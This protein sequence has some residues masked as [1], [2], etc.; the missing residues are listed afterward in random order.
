MNPILIPHHQINKNKWDACINQS[1]HP[2]TTAQSWYLDLAAPGWSALVA[3]DYRAVM[4]LPF[5]WKGPFR[6]LVQPLLVQQL[7]VFS[8]SPLS[9]WQAG[10]FY[11]KT[12]SMRP[13]L[14]LNAQN[15][16]PQTLQLRRQT[17]FI[18]PLN[19]TFTI[20]QKGFSKNCK[21]NLQKAAAFNLAHPINIDTRAFIAFSQKHAAFHFPPQAWNT[22]R[23]IVDTALARENGFCQVVTDNQGSPLAMAFFLKD[24]HRITFLSG[25]S[26]PKGLQQK[27]MFLMMGHVI[28][29]F[30][31]QNLL[32]DFEGSSIGSIA[33]FYSGF[34]AIP[35]YYYQWTHPLMRLILQFRNIIKTKR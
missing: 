16:L 19:Q 24:S 15:P 23:Q 5:V 7:G 3:D 32:L 8:Q 10:S 9:P 22:L 33:R 20:L 29:K 1:T 28:E 35:E 18:L 11:R 25:T 12:Q 21:R 13:F 4:P 26:S 34:G 14:N 31:N 2:L 17:N 27:A 30:C 6:F